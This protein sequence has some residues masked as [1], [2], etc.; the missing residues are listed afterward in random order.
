[1]ATSYT[2]SDRLANL[3]PFDPSIKT[4]WGT[5][6]SENMVLVDQSLDGIATVPLSGTTATLTALSGA[7]DQS[8]PRMQSYTGAL[9]ATCTVT[10]PNV[11]KWGFARNATTGG[12]NVVLSAGAG[13]SFTLLPNG[14]WYTYWS[15]G[16]GNV[17]GLAAASGGQTITGDLTV[18]GSAVIGQSLIAGSTT[19]S[20]LTVSGNTTHDGITFFGTSGQFYANP[21]NSGAQ[22]LAFGASQ[23]LQFVPGTGFQLTTGGSVNIT[24]PG[25]V[26]TSGKLTVNG[27][28]TVQG[29]SPV[30]NNGGTYSINITG[31]AG[32]ATSATNATNAANATNASN[33]PWTGITGK[34]YAFNQST[35]VGAGVVFGTLTASNFSLGGGTFSATVT[36]NGT[37]NLSSTGCFVIQSSVATSP[38][39]WSFGASFNAAA[40]YVGA[41]FFTASDMRLKDDVKEITSDQAREWIMRGRPVTFRWK[42]GGRPSSGF[43][44]QEEHVN[45]R[46]DALIP[47]PDDRAEF[48]ES[49]G[50][51][52]PGYRL[53]R[54]Y[55]H[56]VAYLTAALQHV[57]RELDEV[58][59]KVK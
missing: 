34:P 29:A 27:T 36:G 23:F 42:D 33:V 22:L 19:L 7:P 17:S 37:S 5:P 49:D 9:S 47:V 3:V 24:A 30:L 14:L 28:L 46:G 45:G 26:V 1:M 44:A 41:G 35:D 31:S 10:V 20:S 52:A 39:S 43:I 12:Q 55:N 6:N 2:T 8:R 21:N 11:Q 40:G 59:A 50:I 48:A 16:A 57:L 58:K 53:T 25:G 54:D 32:S 51:V 56:D 13:T 15:D 4:A 18:S 38:A